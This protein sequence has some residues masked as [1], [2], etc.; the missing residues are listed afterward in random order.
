MGM[1]SIAT[2]VSSE[3]DLQESFARL[4]GEHRFKK[5]NPGAYVEYGARKRRGGKVFYFNFD[6]AREMGLLPPKKNERDPDVLTPELCAVL[7]DTF[8]IVIINEWDLKK[9]IQF[10]DTEIKPGKYMAT[11]YL[12]LQ[13]PS[14][15]GKTS[16]D[17]RGIWN[18]EIT[19]RGVTWDV[20]SSGTGATCLSPATAIS[21]KF[22]RSGDPR[23]CY[24]NG[25]NSLDD[26][27]AAALMSELFHR[28]GISTE[29]T[30]VLISFPGGSSINVRAGKNLLRPSHLFWHLKQGN[31]ESLQRAV[32]YCLSR[33][34]RNGALVLSKGSATPYPQTLTQFMKKVATDFARA[35]ARYR[36][37]YVFCWMDWDG[38]NILC[39]GGIIDYGSIRR[40][41]GFHAGYRYDDGD[42]YSTRLGEQKAHA[43]YIVQTFAQMEDFLLSG[44]KKPIHRF[45][46][47]GIAR[48]FDSVFESELQ[49]HF[50][51]KL[52]LSP[53]QLKHWTE[54]SRRESQLASNFF[55]AFSLLEKKQSQRGL[56]T[57]SDG[58]ATHALFI[59]SRFI[60]D[61]SAL[62]DGSPSPLGHEK[63][64]QHCKSEFATRSDLKNRDW[65]RKQWGELEKTFQQFAQ[66]T[67]AQN[68]ESLR[69]ILRG[70]RMRASIRNAPVQVT[71]NG[72]LAVMEVFLKGAHSQAQKDITA[73][74]EAVA[75]HE[76]QKNKK[77]PSGVPKRVSGALKALEKYEEGL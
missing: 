17:G 21:G 18:G 53:A 50:L 59:M 40:F 73:F 45:K 38:D 54:S 15:V 51:Y 76:T 3:F 47:S 41:G 11:R 58:E 71:G 27:L 55:R 29:R 31:K 72:I 64:T 9:K 77:Q 30:L 33:E 57:V 39:D 63:L 34:Q 4:N 68:G 25:Y 2:R 62:W 22:F 52:G 75:R 19:H 7:L 46:N 37:D 42:R 70:W 67:A 1:R 65:L 14:R 6:L 26:G 13:H 28:E 48:L 69:S 66:V 20:M 49:R 24:G 36:S 10:K 5:T 35:A 60:R 16:G 74:F 44:S 8:S 32:D 61:Y 23:V 12:Q 43:R 56:E